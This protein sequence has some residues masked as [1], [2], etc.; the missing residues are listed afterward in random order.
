M[1]E[2]LA[3]TACSPFVADS[4]VRLAAEADASASSAT[5]RIERVSASIASLTPTTSRDCVWAPPAVASIA[6]IISVA[7]V[8]T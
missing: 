4:S 8:R 5:R 3:R 2:R 6:P 7:P 1:P